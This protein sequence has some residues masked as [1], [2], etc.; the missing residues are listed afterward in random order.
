MKNTDRIKVVFTTVFTAVN[1][2]L[3]SLAMPLYIL[4]LC[5][6]ID[7][8][9]GI[10]ASVYRGER[11]SSKVGFHGIAKKVCMWL[12]VAVG[13]VTDYLLLAV[14]QTMGIDTGLGCVIALAVTFWLIANELISILENIDCIGTPLPPFLEKLISYVK[15]K[16]EQSGTVK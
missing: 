5:N 16:T 7:Y 14:G 8:T 6:I 3:G 15:E 2:F 9:T 12:L 11:V 4:V 13:A 1:S 10:A